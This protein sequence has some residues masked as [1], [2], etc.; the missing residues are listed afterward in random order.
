VSLPYSDYFPFLQT[1]PFA[2][3]LQKNPTLALSLACSN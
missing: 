2:G 1:D 3:S